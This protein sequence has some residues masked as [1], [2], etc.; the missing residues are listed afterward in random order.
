MKLKVISTGS[1]GNAYILETENEALLI[2]CGVNILDIKKALDFNYHK[3]VGCI[4]TH[5]H[6]DHCKSINEVMELGINTYSGA[7][8]FESINLK[9]IHRARIIAS[10]QSVKIGN[11]NVMAFDV[12]HDAAEP[13]GYLIEH[14]ECGKVLFL[15]DTNYCK[16]TFPE[17]NN[18]IIES[19]FSKEI[20]DRKFGAGSSKEFL[21]DR[22]LRSHFSLENCKDMLAAND[23]SK[24]NNIVLIHLSDSNSNEKQFVKE[25]TELT[26]KNVTAAVKGLQIDFNKTPF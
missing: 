11:F 1:I 21:R 12:H 7:K 23:L 26:G 17:L 4:V 6:Q 14:P 15:T 2:E 10:K 8:T 5:E 16:Y 19:N 22:I 13:L 20:I 25:V 3:V 9:S 18:I 24:V